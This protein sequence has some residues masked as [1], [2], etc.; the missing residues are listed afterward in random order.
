MKTPTFSARS[1]HNWISI[2]LVI[3]LFIIAITSLFMAHEK[4]LDLKSLSWGAQTPEIRSVLYG[5]HDL[6]ML[7][8]KDDV[9]EWIDN[10]LQAI[11]AL[12]GLEARFIKVLADSSILIAGKGGLWLRHSD[13]KW[14]Q[15]YAG[16]IHGLQIISDGH[17]LI[18]D[19]NVGTML[20]TDQGGH[21]QQDS[22]VAALLEQLP[23]RPYNLEKLIHDL[24][25][26]KAFFGK[27]LEWIWIDVLALVLGFLCLTGAYIWWKS[28]YNK[29]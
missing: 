29:Q 15:K 22:K 6:L 13:Q 12:Q 16:D 1:W 8:S 26:G 3:P 23:A 10:R 11:P 24:H 7:A 9:Y 17:W 20:S 27:H 28:Q 4:S 21:W 2:A 25:T 14:R 18:V 19:K 5:K